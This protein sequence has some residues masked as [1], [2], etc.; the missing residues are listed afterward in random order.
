MR[1][2]QGHENKYGQNM[3]TEDFLNEKSSQPKLAESL[4]PLI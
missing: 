2:K 3:V 4:K 1:S